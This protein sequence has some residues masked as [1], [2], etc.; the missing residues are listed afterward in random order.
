MNKSTKRN[1]RL[2]MLLSL[3]GLIF[4][5]QPKQLA[6]RQNFDKDWKF[7]LGDDSLAFQ[8]GYEDGSWRKLNVPHDWSIEGEFSADAPS[9]T[10]G[11]ALP[12]GIGWYRKSFR[13]EK[14]TSNKNFYIDFDGVFCNSEVWIN[15][16]FLGKRPYGYISFRYDLTPYLNYG[17]SENIL[18]VRVDNSAQPASRWYTGSGI[19]RHVWLVE[20]NPVHVAH[21]GTFVTTPEVSETLAK[22]HLDIQLENTDT[23][24]QEVLVKSSVLDSQGTVLAK[25]ESTLTA[26]NGISSLTQNFELNNP[27]L[28]SPENPNLYQVKSEVFKEGKLVDE[29]NTPLGLRW[30]EFTPDKGFFLNGKPY[31]LHGVNQHHDLGALGAAVNTRAMERQLEI[32]K[33]MGVNGIRMAHNPPAPELLHLCDKMGFLVINESFDEWKKTKAKKGYHLYWDEWHKRDLEDMILRDRNHPSIFVWSIGNEIPEQF[34]TTGIRITRE[35]ADIVKSLDTTRP[36]TAALTETDPEKNNLYKSGALDLLSFNYKHEEY[37]KFPDRYPGECMLASENMSALSSRGHYDFPSDSV[38][39]WPPAYNAPFDGNPDLT[40]SSFDNCIAYWGAT[41]ED[42]WAV[43]KNNDF[44]PGMFIWS[45]FDYIGEPLPY[46]YPA[47]SSY[48]GII[49]LC[50]FPKDVYYMYQSEWTDKTVLHLFPHWNW[51]EGQTVDLWAY[52]NNADEVELFVN[53]VSQGRKSKEKDQFHVMWRVPFHA[54]SVRAVSYKNGEKVAEQEIHTAGQ[55]AKIELIAD[56][57]NIKADG[58]DLSFITVKV[59]DKD[60]NM[61]PDAANLINFNVDGEGFVAG[62]DNGYQAST[63]PF[64]ASYRKAFNG[65]CLVIV[66]STEHAGNIKITASSD[67]L[68]S[69]SL[70]LT[71]N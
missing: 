16:H 48:L 46:P 49:D 15:G 59:T 6:D 58:S 53:G 54:G 60:G 13:L 52:Y 44:I 18:A 30:F 62:V 4:S 25:A 45:G 22:V 10:E 42:T 3:T 14:P 40:A 64:K 56:R 9:T 5:C 34:D 43:V 27:A 67:G 47:R 24:E 63:D 61:V 7:M 17:E 26:T 12:T 35:L 31:K 20:K 33:E 68:E 38:R 23:Q 66:Q 32:L 36:I 21:W 8:A 65:M 50:G 71:S 28:W 69:N 19:Y 29:Y 11:G 2:L 57:N 55:A 37:L 39:I 1:I 51:T 70:T 41:H